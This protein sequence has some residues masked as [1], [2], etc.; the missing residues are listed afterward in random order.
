MKPEEPQQPVL[1]A[2]L[3]GL[4]I[5]ICLY[6][7]WAAGFDWI[8]RALAGGVIEQCLGWLSRMWLYFVWAF[9]A[10]AILASFFKRS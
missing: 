7:V 4:L 6:L 2:I 1:L 3:A 10:L 5:F 9:F 8:C